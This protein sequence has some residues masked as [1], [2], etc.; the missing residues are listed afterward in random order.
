MCIDKV[1]WGWS[2]ET[3]EITWCVFDNDK[4]EKWF[5]KNFMRLNSTPIC[6]QYVE[7][8]CFCVDWYLSINLSSS[9]IDKYFMQWKLSWMKGVCWVL[10]GGQILIIFHWN[11]SVVSN[12]NLYLARSLSSIAVKCTT[13]EETLKYFF[14]LSYIHF[15]VWRPVG[16]NE[17]SWNCDDNS[18]RKA[19][20][21]WRNWHGK[22]HG[23]F[24]NFSIWNNFSLFSIC[25]LIKFNWVLL[26]KLLMFYWKLIS[27][28]FISSTPSTKENWS[29][30]SVSGFTWMKQYAEAFENF[31]GTEYGTNM[32]QF[33]LYCPTKYKH[34]TQLVL[35]EEYDCIFDTKINT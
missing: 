12:F 3:L 21:F 26:V 32:V 14:S 31:N 7:Y 13:G 27:T 33:L 29:I 25:R 24:G 17:M 2:C 6:T 10:E 15:D 9:I 23:N 20:K 11:V 4:K 28:I 34:E 16:Y 5:L 35:C 30:F 22:K 1:F 19:T 8:K 18:S